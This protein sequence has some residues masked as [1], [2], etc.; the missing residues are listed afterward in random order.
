MAAQSLGGPR[1]RRPRIAAAC[2]RGRRPASPDR[3]AAGTVPVA[4]L[5]RQQ[6]AHARR[7]GHEQRRGHHD[8]GRAGGE[9]PLR[10]AG[11]QVPAGTVALLDRPLTARPHSFQPRPRGHVLVHLL[12]SRV[13][14]FGLISVGLWGIGCIFSRVQVEPLERHGASDTVATPVKAHLYDGSTIVYRRGVLITR[15]TIR[16]LEG[17]AV[18]YDLGLDSSTALP[19]PLDSVAGMEAFRTNVDAGSTIIVSTL[20]TAGTLVGAALLA[21]AIFGSCP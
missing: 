13:R 12:R 20:A 7:L 8:R 18:R 19:L 9:L 5:G 16:S 1:R 3:V 4:R 14:A 11:A 2:A 6:R 17:R 10:H 15:D 21:V